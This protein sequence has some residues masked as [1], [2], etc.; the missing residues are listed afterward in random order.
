MTEGV[1]LD[2]AAGSRWRKRE[3]P[4][5]MPPVHGSSDPLRWKAAQSAS[6]SKMKIP[7]ARPEGAVAAVNIKGN[8]TVGVR[9]R[10]ARNC[11]GST[12]VRRTQPRDL[13]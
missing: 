13:R 5:W 6:D 8:K 3:P 12:P 10:T 1:A 4:E 7:L 11:G 9:A 2:S